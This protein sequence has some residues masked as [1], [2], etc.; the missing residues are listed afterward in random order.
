MY[1]IH[2]TQIFDKW[3]LALRDKRAQAIIA[4][5]ID[6]LRNG[7][8]GDAKHVG[9]GVHELRIHHGAGYRIY[10]VSRD[11]QIVILLCGGNKSTQ[12]SDIETAKRMTKELSI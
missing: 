5:R 10:F 8:M 9:G 1:E 3:L 6:R 4:A 12:T 11:G 7:N 2:K